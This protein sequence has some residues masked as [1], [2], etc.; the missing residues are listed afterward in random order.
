MQIRRAPRISTC[1]LCGRD[2]TPLEDGRQEHPEVPDCEVLYT[3]SYGIALDNDQPVSPIVI[4]RQR[5]FFVGNFM[6]TDEATMQV[7]AKYGLPRLGGPSTGTGWSSWGLWQRCRYAW[8]LRYLDR[9]QPA[10]H[11]EAAALAIGG[12]FHTFLAIYYQRMIDPS[13]PLSPEGLHAELHGLSEP[14]YIAEAWRIAQAYMLYYK[15]EQIVPL[16]V[17]Q[18]LV[19]PRTGE[20][21]RYD[22]IAFYPHEV[23]GRPAGTYILEHKTA[24]RFDYST[25]NGW[26][27]E[28]EVLGQM[29]L[30]ERL[31][32]DKRWGALKGVIVNITG[33]QPKEIQFH[34]TIIA[35]SAF[36]ASSHREDLRQQAAEMA[37]ARATGR[38][39]RSRRNCVDRHGMC[40]W[41][42]HCATGERIELPTESAE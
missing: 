2:L 33:K 38:F 29:D 26:G 18:D 11:I 27:N 5:A 7:F 25:L 8:K 39:P 12:L 14:A 22:L 17:E 4:N 13:Y 35:P 24:A 9:A 20:S 40:D 28:G 21:C 32:L 42:D 31:K 6:P 10:M 3:D 23:A 19:D 16:A 37:L 15:H 41:F 34:R 30:W 36:T 1:F